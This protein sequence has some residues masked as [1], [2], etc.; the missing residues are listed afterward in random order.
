MVRARGWVRRFGVRKEGV[1][2]PIP[3]RP[4]R[5]HALLP[6]LIFEAKT[7]SVLGYCPFYLIRSPRGELGGDFDRD[8]HLGVRVGGEYGDDFLG[9][10]Y[11]T[12]FGCGGRYVG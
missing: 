7:G 3:A 1:L 9:D 12:H 11:E 6:R 2:L 4:V 8:F 5:V 10:L